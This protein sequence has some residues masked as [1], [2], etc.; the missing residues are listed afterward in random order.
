MSKSDVDDIILVRG[1][2]RIPK[3][4][5]FIKDMFGVKELCRFINPEEVGAYGAAIKQEPLAIILMPHER[6]MKGSATVKIVGKADGSFL[7]IKRE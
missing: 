5:H 7:T 2:T 6:N 4:Q 1:S 3:L